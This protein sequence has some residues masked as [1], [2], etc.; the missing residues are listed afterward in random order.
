[1]GPTI[2]VSTTKTQHNFILCLGFTS[3]C[4]PEQQDS[5]LLS[6]KSGRQKKRIQHIM[7]YLNF[8][9][10]LFLSSIFC[11]CSTVI[12]RCYHVEEK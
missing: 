6:K 12:S 8:P 11:T 5:M 1:M 4:L 3:V 7:Q 2:F 10:S 9:P